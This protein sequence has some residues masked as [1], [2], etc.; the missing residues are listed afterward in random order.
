MAPNVYRNSD[1]S[2]EGVG[3]HVHYHAKDRGADDVEGSNYPTVDPLRSRPH[4]MATNWPNNKETNR[5]HTMFTLRVGK[6]SAE[7]AES[8][9]DLLSM[10]TSQ[11]EVKGVDQTQPNGGQENER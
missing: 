2:D 8:S 10:T 7:P 3:R 11:Q 1:E 9:K 6:P 5:N 4:Q